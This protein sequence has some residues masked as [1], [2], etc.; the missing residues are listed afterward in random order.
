MVRVLVDFVGLEG[1]AAHVLYGPPFKEDGAP[2]PDFVVRDDAPP[3][4]H[5]THGAGSLSGPV[6]SVP[7]APAVG[8]ANSSTLCSGRTS[9][10]R[11]RMMRLTAMIRASEPMAIR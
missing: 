10:T 7:G 11:R 2:L 3:E 4:R 8:S 9:G 6:G 1:F 5:G